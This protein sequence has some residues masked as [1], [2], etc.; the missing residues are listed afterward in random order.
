MCT[1]IAFEKVGS[2]FAKKYKGYRSVC[3]ID[4]DEK[5][6]K[7]LELSD[8]ADKTRVATICRTSTRF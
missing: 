2:K 6:R 7:A 8:L 4:S 1:K 5:R 3:M